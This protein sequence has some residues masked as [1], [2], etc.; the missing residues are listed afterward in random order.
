M[1]KYF[2]MMGL[3][4]LSSLSLVSCGGGNNQNAPQASEEV[5]GEK[6][7]FADLVDV[8]IDMA[9]LNLEM[10]DKFSKK[11]LSNEDAREMAVKL[12]EYE[13]KAEEEGA[14]YKGKAFKFEA[15]E[16]LGTT[17][18]DGVISNV[19]SGKVLQV[20]FQAKPAG[21]ISG[22]IYAFF[23]DANSQLVMKTI[24]SLRSDNGK[25]DVALRMAVSGMRK[26]TPVETWEKIATIAKVMIVSKEEYN[27]GLVPAVGSGTAKKAAA[28]PVPEFVMTDHGVDKVT[29]G[30]D[31]SKLPKSINGLYDQVAVKSEYN[32]MEDETTT[33][34]SFTLKGK[35][36]MT[37]MADGDG[38]VCHIAVVAPG[39]AVKIGD[40]YFQIGS[41]V[42]DLM[43]AK[44]VKGDEAYAA[45]YGKMQFDGDVNNHICGISVGSAW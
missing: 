23:L 7:V 4:A 11:E 1:K 45:I 12:Q 31:I 8:Y 20:N 32:A 13:K 3:L 39:V 28:Q 21:E 37:A 42:K 29:L 25:V 17:F 43:K 34:A 26:V 6:G 10:E 15:S 40:S 2:M 22:G 16:S 19:R 27:S 35:E 33:T 5:S 24:G 41:S 38:K 14:A 18:V 44:G 30:A 9:K 36:V